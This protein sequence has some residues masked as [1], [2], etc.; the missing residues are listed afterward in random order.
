MWTRAGAR[1]PRSEEGTRVRAEDRGTAGTGTEDSPCCSRGAARS[2]CQHREVAGRVRGGLR[3]ARRLSCLRR[4]RRSRA[5]GAGAAAPQHPRPPASAVRRGSSPQPPPRAADS[6]LLR[7]RRSRRRKWR[8]G[9][10]PPT[11]RSRPTMPR[12]ARD[13][14]G[15]PPGGGARGAAGKLRSPH[16]AEPC[17]RARRGRWGGAPPP[18]TAAPRPYPPARLSPE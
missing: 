16:S 18:P 7:L 14:T 17:G 10:P 13:V 15:P 3:G 4:G 9:V 11:R 1:G 5:R 6:A 12:A 2:R 8:L